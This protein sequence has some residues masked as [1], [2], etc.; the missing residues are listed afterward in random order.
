[1]ILIVK[2]FIFNSLDILEVLFAKSNYLI[3]SILTH[4]GRLLYLRYDDVAPARFNMYIY[5]CV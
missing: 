4:R 2:F 1:M 5:F 3:M